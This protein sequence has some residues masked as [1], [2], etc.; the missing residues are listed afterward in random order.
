MR[1][2]NKEKSPHDYFRYFQDLI[3]TKRPAIIWQ[4]DGD[5]QQRRLFRG[6]VLACRNQEN[7]LKIECIEKNREFSL[8]SPK[9]YFYVEQVQLMFSANKKGLDQLQLTT[10]LPAELHRL[11]ENEHDKIL[12]A[13][14]QIDPTRKMEILR[15]QQRAADYDFEARA[16]GPD[17]YRFSGAGGTDDF[18]NYYVRVPG[19]RD[20]TLEPKV[21]QSERDRSIF[22]EELSFVS[23]DEEDK[24][25]AAKRGS[26]RARPPEGKTVTMQ[27][28]SGKGSP[29]VFPLFDLSRGGLA[30]LSF[31][32]KEYRAGD[33]VHIQSF[34]H[35]T[36]DRPMVAEVK[37]VRPADDL[38]VQFKVGMQFVD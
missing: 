16:T 22:E 19:F 35:K 14:A 32:E 34:D 3:I 29:G 15:Y 21:E 1:V 20:E 7:I 33:L 37:S 30:V 26:P 4:V 9:V 18:D 38:G 11:S 12:Q 24:L 6:I 17:E 23:L 36:L 27:L 5:A 31:E 13:F 25:Y 10:D 2:I 8:S 28:A